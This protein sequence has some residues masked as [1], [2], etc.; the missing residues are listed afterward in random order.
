MNC[1]ECEYFRDELSF[2]PD[3]YDNR[4]EETHNLYCTRE[5]YYPELG[6]KF[7]TSNWWHIP[8]NAWAYRQAESTLEEL[9]N[10]A[11]R[12]LQTRPLCVYKTGGKPDEKRMNNTELEAAMTRYERHGVHGA[13]AAKEYR[14]LE[15]FSQ[16]EEE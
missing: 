14:Q 8:Y 9:Y 6:M 4:T 2:K 1:R 11:F 7:P 5:I 15:L 10:R 3:R 13:A 12:W 16:R